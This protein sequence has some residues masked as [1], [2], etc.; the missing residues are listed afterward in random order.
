M[1]ASE[2]RI[3][4]PLENAKRLSKKDRLGI[5]TGSHKI[6][7]QEILMNI[8]KRTFIQA[9]TQSIFSILMHGPLEDDFSRIFTRSSHGDMYK[10]MRG[11]PGC[12]QELLRGSV[13]D[14][15]QDLHSRTP[16]KIQQGRHKRTWCWRGS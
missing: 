4:E 6:F 15:D 5:I 3:P 11:S 12:L 1:S 14:P 16:K 8:P 13:K 7:S 9:P 10:I 2:D